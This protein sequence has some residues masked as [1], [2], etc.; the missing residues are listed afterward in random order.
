M[1]RWILLPVALGLAVWLVASLRRLVFET[2]RS[3]RAR[4]S[5]LSEAQALLSESR[6]RLEPSGFPRVAGRF[7]GHAVDL[8]VVPDALTFRKLPALW[9]LATL[10]EPQPLTGETRVMI[11][12]TGIE[13]FSTF[14]N[15][16]VEASLPPGFPDTCVLRTEGPAHLPPSASLRALGSLF[17]HP[18]TKE[19]VL[20][21]TGLR[22]VR[23]V[24]EA[25]RAAYLLFRDSDL[26]ATPIPAPM[27]RELLDSLI[28]LSKELAGS[29]PVGESRANG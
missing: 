12:P 6:E 21:P 25:P 28:D 23:L 16:P 20:A 17:E 13:P 10:T 3:R 7:Q 22:L 9:L 24:E 2:R 4:A 5:V 1:S 26:G 8:Q 27:V 11:R 14:S 19:A 15:L 29:D 18:A